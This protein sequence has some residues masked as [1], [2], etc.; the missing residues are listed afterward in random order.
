MRFP[1]RVFYGY[2]ISVF[3]IE[4]LAL[5]SEYLIHSNTV[6]YN[7]GDIVQL[8]LIL[9]Y[10]SVSMNSRNIVILLLPLAVAYGIF[11]L[12]F[13]QIDSYINSY[14]LIA[15]GVTVIGL[16]TY[17]MILLSRRQTSIG[18]SVY[19]PFWIDCALLFYWI[20]SMLNFLFFN[21]FSEQDAHYA[22]M[23]N[24]VHLYVNIAMYLTFTLMFF[25]LRQ[26][27]Q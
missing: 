18:L 21:H 5:A 12:L 22:I 4:L 26:L 1:L 20:A 24:I 14:F 7:V 6:V 15:S 19:A 3:L 10:F 8:A 23:L 13:V 11:N 25:Q 9:C 27:I 17:H 2:L 16:S